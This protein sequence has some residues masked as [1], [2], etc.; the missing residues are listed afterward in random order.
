MDLS[1]HAVGGPARSLLEIERSRCSSSILSILRR[2]HLLQLPDF[3]PSGERR[4]GFTRTTPAEVGFQHAFK[5]RGDFSE[6]DPG[7]DLPTD[8]RIGSGSATENN[9]VPVDRLATGL[10]LYALKTDVSD[11]VLRA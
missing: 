2:E 5:Q 6:G 7:E 4:K 10:N 11:I 9:V 1:T 8:G 3:M